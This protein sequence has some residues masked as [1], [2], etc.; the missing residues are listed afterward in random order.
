MKTLTLIMVFLLIVV[1]C[2]RNSQEEDAKAEKER[3]ELEKEYQATAQRIQELCSQYNAVMDW[4][5]SVEDV[6]SPFTIELEEALIRAD[7]RP[8]LLLGN[9]KDITK[10]SDGYWAYFTIEEPYTSFDIH[11]FLRCTPEQVDEIMGHRLCEYAVI[12]QVSEVK[13]VSYLFAASNEIVINA[14]SPDCDPREVTII[15]T[16][17]FTDL[18]IA[19]GICSALV[20]YDLEWLSGCDLSDL[21]IG[22]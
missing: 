9:V 1:G 4:T 18:F 17:P 6:W 2:D 12:A 7:S 22:K 3:L 14:E 21:L 11:F 13:K 5:Q 16:D 20:S 15:E 8:V 10:K 19:N